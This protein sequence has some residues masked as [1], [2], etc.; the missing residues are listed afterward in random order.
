MTYNDFTLDTVLEAFQVT[1]SQKELF[2][3]VPSLDV[4]SLL[5]GILDEGLSLAYIS[6]KA[7]SEI[8][9][10]PILLTVRKLF[11]RAFSI[12]SG[13]RFDV[14]PSSGLSGECDFILSI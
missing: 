9:I 7:R 1:L 14:E 10:M 2:S 11:L 5:Q 13:Q 3:D 4:P 12:Y 8:I 6:E